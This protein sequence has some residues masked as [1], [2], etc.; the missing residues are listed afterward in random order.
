VLLLDDPFTHVDGYTQ[1]V[2]WE[3]MKSLLAG[4]TLIIVSSKPLPVA[5]L[6]KVV[7]LSEGRVDDQGTPGEVLQRN[8]YMKLFY[9]VQG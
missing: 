1:Q 5:D 6:D 8:S 7:V 4:T 3:K 2:I 9:E